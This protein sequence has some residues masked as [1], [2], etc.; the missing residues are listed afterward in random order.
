LQVSAAVAVQPGC[1]TNSRIPSHFDMILLSDCN[2]IITET[3][4]PSK[5]ALPYVL[6]FIDAAIAAEGSDD[7]PTKQYAKYSFHVLQVSNFD[8]L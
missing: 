4:P 2:Q 3:F 1:V 8:V 5:T 7:D 6:N